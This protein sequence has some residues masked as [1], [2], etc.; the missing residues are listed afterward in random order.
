MSDLL[1]AIFRDDSGLMG[2]DAYQAAQIH[3]VGGDADRAT[4]AAGRATQKAMEADRRVERLQLV[5]QAMWEM[6]R[7]REGFTDPQLENMILEIDLRDGVKDGRMAREV[8]VCDACG[9]KTGVRHHRRCFYCGNTLQ[10]EH[11]VER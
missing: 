2:V 3:E 11:V 6:M 1:N 10:A 9:R 7:E 8:A 4:A 5:V